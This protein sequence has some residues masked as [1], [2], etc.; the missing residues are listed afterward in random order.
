MNST[1][2]E[3]G[4]L[5]NNRDSTELTKGPKIAGVTDKKGSS[6]KAAG[7]R[8]LT[9]SKNVKLASNMGDHK[10]KSYSQVMLEKEEQILQM[11]KEYKQN[12]EMITESGETITG[13]EVTERM[14]KLI[15]AEE[16]QQEAINVKSLRLTK[17]RFKQYL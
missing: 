4:A 11:L 10:S 3:T 12:R 5:A 7:L 8:R 16:G 1:A 15:A 2:R 6:S 13:H 17:K 14:F 9:S